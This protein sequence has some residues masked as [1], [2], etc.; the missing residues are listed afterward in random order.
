MKPTFVGQTPEG[1]EEHFEKAIQNVIADNSQATSLPD[2]PLLGTPLRDMVSPGELYT[3]QGVIDAAEAIAGHAITQ[4]PPLHA[5]LCAAQAYIENATA[6]PDVREAR[7]KQLAP[8][9]SV[10]EFSPDSWASEPGSNNAD[11]LQDIVVAMGLLLVSVVTVR[12]LSTKG[13]AA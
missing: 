12:R 3:L 13:Q 6:N 1:F 2:T 9:P 8:P 7:A 4:E 11:R 5:A 10:W